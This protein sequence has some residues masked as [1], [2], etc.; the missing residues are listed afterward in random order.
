[1][2][3]NEIDGRGTGTFRKEKRENWKP[4]HSCLLED[5]WN[6]AVVIINNLAIFNLDNLLFRTMEISEMLDKHSL[7]KSKN[8]EYPFIKGW[9]ENEAHFTLSRIF[10]PYA[11]NIIF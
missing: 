11:D 3:I 2:T 10:V 8:A 4:L 5:L 1:M 9:Q 6:N 7:Y